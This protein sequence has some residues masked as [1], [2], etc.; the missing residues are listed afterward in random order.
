M[1]RNNN[2]QSEDNRCRQPAPLWHCVT[3]ALFINVLIIIIIIIIIITVED[4]ILQHLFATQ[5]SKT[6]AQDYSLK[7]C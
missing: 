4:N 5:S 1:F 3:L 2:I 7:V 6:V